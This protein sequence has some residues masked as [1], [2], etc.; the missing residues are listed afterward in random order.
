MGTAFLSPPNLAPQNL[1]DADDFARQRAFFAARPELTATPLHRCS[2]L[3]RHLGI[4]ELLV[5]DE[6][7]RFG[8]NAFKA[9]GAM[10][11]IATLSERGEL[12]PGDTLVCASEGNHGRAVAHAA[13]G[14]GCA[15]KVYM[16]SRVTPARVNAI[17]DE[18]AEVVLVDGSYDDAVRVMAAEAHGNGW[19]VISDTSWAG[20]TEIPH[21]IM[22]GYTRIL[23][24]VAMQVSGDGL[25]PGLT[26]IFV[27][28]GVGGLL[29]AVACW[30]E[31]R[32]GAERPRVVAVEPASADCVQA[33]MRAGRPT[34]LPGPF[35]TVMGG[36][37]CGVMSPS[38]FPAVQTLVDAGIG[39]EDDDAFEAMRLLARPVRPDPSIACGPSGAA[40][41]GGLLAVLGDPA[42]DAVRRH[43]R[44]DAGATVVVLATEGV[45]D[46]A[47]FQEALA[48][49]R[50]AASR[51]RT[52]RPES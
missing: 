16:S 11:A 23:D 42:L 44:L 24:E 32:Y 5:K 25:Q 1:F 31:W 39:I 33:S 22:L 29:A 7:A 18:G 21:L 34:A 41:L 45:T 46:P 30:A 35:D 27:P 52:L 4:G 49:P 17:R 2:G 15:A 48:R 9:A 36:L 19:L 6:T 50:H 28:A 38:V 8:L 37:R 12:R 10:F 3:A 13:R 14:A 20:Y 40:A 51:N 47:L 43:L 26:T